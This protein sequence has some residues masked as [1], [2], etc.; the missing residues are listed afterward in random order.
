MSKRL[1]WL[2]FL[3]ISLFRGFLL[4]ELPVNTTDISRHL[5]YGLYF[6]RGHWEAMAMPL[7]QINDAFSVITWSNLPFNYPLYS[8]IPFI[9]AQF[10]GGSIFAAKLILTLCELTN[11]ILVYRLSGSRLIGLLYWALPVSMWYVS[12]EAQFEPWQNLFILL[13]IFFL[14]SNTYLAIATFLIAVQIKLFSL[15]L[16]PLILAEVCSK[17][18][19]INFTYLAAIALTLIFPGLLTEYLYSGWSNVFAFSHALNFNPWHFHPSFWSYPKFITLTEII[20]Y[21]LFSCLLLFYLSALF[22]KSSQRIIWLAPLIFVLFLKISPNAQ[23]W[24]LLTLAALLPY[25]RAAKQSLTLLALIFLTEPFG[26]SQL[27]FGTWLY[28]ITG[29]FG[30]MNVFTPWQ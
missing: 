26:L 5:L 23:P 6:S 13:C 11:S 18:R 4:L 28:D 21:Q 25:S 19:E 14:R 15:A 30:K 29:Y 1:F 8:A 3:L 24:Y 12:R 10:F 2:T 27:I 22:I 17:R 7:K 16:L 9:L 20:W